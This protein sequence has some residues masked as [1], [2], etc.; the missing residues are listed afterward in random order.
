MSATDTEGDNMLYICCMYTLK[1]SS[2]LQLSMVM[3]KAKSF[4]YTSSVMNLKH[5]HF[6]MF[7]SLQRE[8]IHTCSILYTWIA[9]KAQKWEAHTNTNVVAE[10]Y[11]IMSEQ[12]EKT[13]FP[14]HVPIPLKAQSQGWILQLADK[15]LSKTVMSSLSFIFGIH[16]SGD[17]TFVDGIF[18]LEKRKWN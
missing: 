13:E 18:T 6:L 17:S 1:K 11:T 4:F 9:T 5:L 7:T 14:R 12:Q 10:R 15:C 3:R 8:R 16:H 2:C